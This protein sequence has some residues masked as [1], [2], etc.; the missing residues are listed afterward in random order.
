MSER[1]EHD[2]RSI[3]SNEI[4]T[5]YTKVE[6]QAM[7]QGNY[8][9]QSPPIQLFTDLPLEFLFPNGVDDSILPITEQKLYLQLS[10]EFRIIL[11]RSSSFHEG[12]QRWSIILPERLQNYGLTKDAWDRISAIGDRDS[13]LQEQLNG[14]ILRI[15]L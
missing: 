10:L 15:F 6:E 9:D 14:L 2:F 12:M 4:D 1:T 8:Q 13:R 5:S 7:N 11:D 3:F